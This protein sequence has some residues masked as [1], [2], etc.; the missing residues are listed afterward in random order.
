MEPGLTPG[1]FA[2]FRRSKHYKPN[3]VVLADHPRFGQIVKLIAELDP[4][5]VRLRG[6][7]SASVSTEAMGPVPLSNIRGRLIWKAANPAGTPA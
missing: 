6:T 3:D 4:P 7:S 1:S 5:N 2:L